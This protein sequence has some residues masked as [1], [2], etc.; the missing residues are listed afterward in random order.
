MRFYAGDIE[1]VIG[2]PTIFGCVGRGFP[3]EAGTIP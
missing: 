3:D 1:I 2:V